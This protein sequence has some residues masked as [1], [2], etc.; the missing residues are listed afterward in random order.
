MLVQVYPFR[1]C[2]VSLKQADISWQDKVSLRQL[3]V[4]LTADAMARPQHKLSKKTTADCVDKQT[5]LHAH[6]VRHDIS[7]E[8]SPTSNTGL[9]VARSYSTDSYTAVAEKA[10]VCGRSELCAL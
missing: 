4:S 5:Q 7:S 2:Q 6:L 1:A 3:E 9:T 10:L 8:V